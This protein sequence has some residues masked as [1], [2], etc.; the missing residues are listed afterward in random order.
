[1]GDCIFLALPVFYVVCLTCAFVK[2]N[3][4]RET[5]VRVV[6]L[7]YCVVVLFDCVCCVVA[8]V[9]LCFCIVA[10]VSRE[11]LDCGVWSVLMSMVVTPIVFFCNVSRETLCFLI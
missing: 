4:S 2:N 5:F 8:G 3:V 10:N 7:I 9:V 1:M 6:C 11:T